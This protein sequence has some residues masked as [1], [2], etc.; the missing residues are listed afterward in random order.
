MPARCM[1]QAHEQ[2][3]CV[4]IEQ[5]EGKWEAMQQ[6]LSRPLYLNNRGRLS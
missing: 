4:L 3:K 2:K 6:D 5:L 1:M